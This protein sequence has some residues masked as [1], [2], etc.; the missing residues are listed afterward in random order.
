MSDDRRCGECD[1]PAGQI[2]PEDCPRVVIERRT[3]YAT[4]PFSLTRIAPVTTCACGSLYAAGRCPC[5][6]ARDA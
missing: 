6:E 2:C 3:S 4:G 5:G 1:T